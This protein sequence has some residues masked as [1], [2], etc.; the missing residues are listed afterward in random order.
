MSNLSLQFLGASETVTGSKYLLSYE[1]CNILIDCGLF[2]GLKP[3]RLKN[4]QSLEQVA[5]SLEAV[6]LTHAH[7]DHSGYIPKLVKE[8]FRGKVYSTKETKEL[9]QILLRDSGYLQEEEANYANRKKFSKHSPALPLYTVRD[10]E[11]SIGHFQ[12]KAFKEA[13]TIGPF[14]ITLFPA[15]HILGAASV[16]V[17][18]PKE[19]LLFSGD[20]GRND[21]LLM[22]P[23]ELPDKADHVI[24]ESTYGGKL[25]PSLEPIESLSEVVRDVV[26]RDGVLLIPSFAVG[27]A[28]TILYCLHQVFKKDPSL[29]VPVFLNSPMS[30]NVTDIYINYSL[31]HRLSKKQCEDICGDVRFV[32]S[33]G[34]S[35]RLNQRPGPMI[36]VSASGMMT[37]G[38]ILHHIKEFAPDK[39]NG[40]LLVGYQAE[41]TRGA[42]LVNGAEEL[43]IHGQYT[44]INAKVYNLDIFSAHADQKGLISW[45]KKLRERPKSLYIVHGERASMDAFRV[46]VRDELG[47]EAE[48]PSLGEKVVFKS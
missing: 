42:S 36:I 1:G 31:G 48:I 23:P 34:E 45:L 28:Q 6:V 10:A 13:F 30:T 20:L 22:K 35:M 18:T 17:R 19:T 3:L 43:K 40:I 4:W 8:G 2:Q 29:E 33:V 5:Q 9:C 47:I 16:F 12:I 41:G 24:I 15:G 11:N 26:R 32:N 27:R 46:K 25:H 14:E 39:K 7:L 37:G 38:R 44:P 21:D